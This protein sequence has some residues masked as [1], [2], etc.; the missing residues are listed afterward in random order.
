MMK[1]IIYINLLV[2]ISFSQVITGKNF[3]DEFPFDKKWES[4]TG[5]EAIYEQFYKG[6]VTGYFT[7][8]DYS[9][10]M[11]EAFIP[12][13]SKIAVNTY[14]LA[15]YTSGMSYDEVIKIVKRYCDNNPQKMHEP[16]A[17]LLWEALTVLPLQE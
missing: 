12:E 6:F 16:F 13:G 2:N 11:F 8:N 3:L 7:A 15:N 9:A 17:T 10:R 5:Q 14:S 4:L 1:I